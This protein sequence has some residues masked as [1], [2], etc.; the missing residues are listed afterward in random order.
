MISTRAVSAT[1]LA[2]LASQVLA[3]VV[4]GYL[5]A[6]DYAPYEGTLL[7]AGAAWQ[8][9]FLPVAHL[10]FISALVWV[11]T[12]LRLAGSTLTRGATLGVIA[13]LLGQVP[14]WLVWYAEQPWPGALVV[15]QLGLELISA[16]AI[17]IVIAAV[18]RV[19]ARTGQQ[20]A[21]T[22]GLSP[23][24][25]AAFAGRGRAPRE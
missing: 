11:Y 10:V 9:L 15:K 12:R 22:P 6:S 8:M 24:L 13:W 7:R 2:F 4:H 19:P 20:D 18:A 17:G 14:L 16:M 5:L 23:L 1:V 3:V 25:P 21:F